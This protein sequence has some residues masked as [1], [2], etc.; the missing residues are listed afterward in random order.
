MSL[1]TA[2]RPSGS[3]SGASWHPA[4]RVLFVDEAA[5]GLWDEDWVDRERGIARRR[6][7]D[8]SVHRIVKSL[9]IPSELQ[10]RLRGIGWDVIIEGVG[11]FFWG[12]GGP[13]RVRS[14]NYYLR[15]SPEQR[16]L[17]NPMIRRDHQPG[18]VAPT[19]SW[20]WRTARRR[21]PS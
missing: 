2:S 14:H 13:A 4:G 11:P 5:H 7:L 17:S 19:G 6:L 18:M 8:G 3:S 9:W 12:H 10:E 20:D 21:L 15:K 16:A 1:H